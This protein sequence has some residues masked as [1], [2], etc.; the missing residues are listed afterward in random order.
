[1]ST[2]SA[3][4]RRGLVR[5]LWVDLTDGVRHGTLLSGFI[6]GNYTVQTVQ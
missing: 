6:D 3:H 1:M 4:H 5:V 2:P